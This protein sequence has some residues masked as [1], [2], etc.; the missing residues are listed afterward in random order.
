VRLG[1]VGCGAVTEQLHLPALRAMGWTPEVLVDPDTDRARRL[2]DEYGVQRVA[3]DAAASAHLVD[4]A[5]V[6]VP[7][8]HHR[9]V[10]CELLEHGVDV[11][12]E[13]PLARTDRECA[14]ILETARD[15]E[16]IL[17]IGLMRRFVKANRWL[18]RLVEQGRL[19]RI[20]RVDVREGYIF[21]W[22]IT[23]FGF[24]SPA[25]GGVLK[26]LGAHTLDLIH[27]HFGRI[28]ELEYRDDALGGAEVDCILEFT[29]ERGI[30]GVLELSRSRS[31]R[32]SFVV[33]GERA[34]VELHHFGEFVY[35]RSTGDTSLPASLRIVP[36]GGQ[37]LLDLFIEQHADW[38][39]AVRDRRPSFVPPEDGAAVV[40]VMERC[41]SERRWWDLPWV[42]A[43][44]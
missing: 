21:D 44:A 23:T 1:V 12:L 27:W 22:P 33:V 38:Y 40:A 15:R 17:G 10:A 34:T 30:P 39:A 9:D 14:E 28:T 8:A 42:G 35:T 16:R 7:I 43:P 6:A 25:N 29:T 41:Y 5:I 36:K 3:G 31:L 18:H 19:G 32:N 2:A 4:T 26:D 37:I 20:E 24:F 11:L 13:K